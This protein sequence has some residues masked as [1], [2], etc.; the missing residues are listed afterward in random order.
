MFALTWADVDFERRLIHIRRS[1]Y[2]GQFGPPENRTSERAIPMGPV[3][4]AVLQSHRQRGGTDTLGLVFPNANGKP[5]EAGNL[6]MRILQPALKELGLPMAGWRAFRRSVATALNELRE[7]VR[8]A[9]QVLGHSSP[10]TTLAFYTRAAEE[11][12]RR[13]VDSWK[14]YCSQMFPSRT[15]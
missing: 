5:F 3:L 1:F 12:Q 8:T 4:A 9:Q 11:S 14:S 2:R 15:G 7:P 6:T 13:A 10:H